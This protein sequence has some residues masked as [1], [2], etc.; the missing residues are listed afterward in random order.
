[1]RGERPEFTRL[2]T[3]DFKQGSCFRIVHNSTAPVHDDQLNVKH[4]PVLFNGKPKA[5][6]SEGIHDA[7]G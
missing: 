3:L 6:A 5:Y 7:F 1:M 2:F 4:D